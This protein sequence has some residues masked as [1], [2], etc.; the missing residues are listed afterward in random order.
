MKNRTA[1]KKIHKISSFKVAT[2]KLQY[3]NHL[4][5]FHLKILYGV[6]LK[7]LDKIGL[8]FHDYSASNIQPSFFKIYKIKEK[9]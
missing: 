7:L 4:V 1:S 9:H 2:R 6:Q 8:L 5:S 3:G